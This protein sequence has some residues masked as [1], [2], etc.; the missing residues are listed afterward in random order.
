MAKSKQISQKAPPPRTLEPSALDVHVLEYCRFDTSAFF[1]EIKRASLYLRKEAE[2]SKR[3]YS[4]KA[5]GSN[6]HYFPA[7][8]GTV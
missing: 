3:Q 6:I 2:V 7:P 8:R 1:W 5:K 4:S